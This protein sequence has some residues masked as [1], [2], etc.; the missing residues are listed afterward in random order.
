M[1][2]TPIPPLAPPRIVSANQIL[3]FGIGEECRE[4]GAA[5]ILDQW[6]RFAPHIGK[7]PGQIGDVAYGVVKNFENS[8]GYLYVAGVAVSTFPPEPV[9]FTR[10]TIP[11]QI[12]AVFQHPG[13]VSTT[14]ET[15]KA[16]YSS[17]LTNAGYK[18]ESGPEFERY[19]PEFDAATGLGG[20]EI[21]VPVKPLAVVHPSRLARAMIYVKDINR[22]IDFYQNTLGLPIIESSRISA[23]VEFESGLALHGIPPSIAATIQITTPPQPREKSAVKLTFETSDLAATQARLRSLNVPSIERPWG[24]TEWLDPEGN[25][26]S[27]AS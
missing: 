1:S 18:K 24:A 7:I 21:W 6:R 22:M 23:Y 16:I 3:V 20:F 8:N 15:W 11:A 10:L 4:A 5:S 25:I 9:D 14:L 17:G 27:L 13:H 19:G 26:F 12:Y 2:Q